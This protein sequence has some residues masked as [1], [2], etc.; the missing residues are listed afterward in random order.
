MTEPNTARKKAK[1]PV[2]L[3][4]AIGYTVSL[5]S[6]A[7][8]FFR[9][10]FSELANHM[11]TLEWSWLLLAMGIQTGAYFLDALRWRELLRPVHKPTYGA[12]TQSV[13]VGMFVNDLL[14]ARA[15]EV[16]RCFLLSYK[17]DIHLPL[18][19]TSSVILRVMDGMWV[20]IY[21]FATVYAIENVAAVTGVM[22]IYAAV[23]IG[24]AAVLLLALFYRH[25]SKRLVGEHQHAGRFAHFLDEIH[26]LGN[27]RE[28]G[29]VCLLSA[30]YWGLQIFAVMAVARADSFYFSFGQMTFLLIFK[31]VGTLVPTAPAG[32]GAFQATTV[33][34]LQR[35]FT[36]TPDA[37]ILAE[38]LFVFLTLPGL[39]GGAI[40]IAM[41]GLKLKE[42]VRHAQAAHA[43]RKTQAL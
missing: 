41:A 6:L 32:L 36:E 10:P 35:F 13:F 23:V 18:V 27:W 12:T 31:N 20:V 25:T 39:I 40:A 15:G 5:T 4:Q 24:L 11:R 43:A 3:A 30:G 28:L 14:P 22:Y 9:F 8:V 1:F 34:A 7:W 38:V 19:I 29:I 42:L 21:Y 33:F 2:W 16:V 17:A 26:N 37:K